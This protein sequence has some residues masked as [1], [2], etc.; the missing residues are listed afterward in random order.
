MIKQLCCV[1][2]KKSFIMAENLFQ[3]C[4]VQVPQA[5][6]LKTIFKILRESLNLKHLL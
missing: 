2:G 1:H 5:G 3:M 4:L 6:N